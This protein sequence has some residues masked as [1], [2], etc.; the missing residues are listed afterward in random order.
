MS[1]F[2]KITFD[3]FYKRFESNE[4][5]DEKELLLFTDYLFFLSYY[6]FGDDASDYVQI[7]NDTFADLKIEE[8]SHIAQ[9]FSI[10]YHKFKINNNILIVENEINENEPYSIENIDDYSF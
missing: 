9:I 2:I 10:N 1:T 7:W 4:L 3:K 8:K 6:E 5:K